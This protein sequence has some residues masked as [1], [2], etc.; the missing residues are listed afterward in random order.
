MRK[1]LVFGKSSRCGPGFE[2]LVD[3][4]CQLCPAGKYL[5]ER[6]ANFQHDA[7]TACLQCPANA[8]CVEGAIDSQSCAAAQEISV[9]GSTTVGDCQCSAGRG[10]PGA[11]ESCADC[12]HGAFS[13][14]ETNSPCQQC[15]LHKNT[16]TTGANALALCK[17]APGF[18]AA[19]GDAATAACAPCGDGFFAPG[20]ADVP[21]VHCGFGTVSATRVS[22]SVC[23]PGNSNA[24]GLCREALR[25]S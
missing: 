12:P 25:V 22:D 20:G 14:G 4:T 5:S 7:P 17:C 24:R 21:C 2:I 3:E 18:G 15:P 13:P 1:A 11:S 6:A 19:A 23:R 9:P 8:Y 16:S 10:R